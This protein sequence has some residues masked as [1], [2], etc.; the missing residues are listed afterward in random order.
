[1]T[2]RIWAPK[3]CWRLAV[4]LVL[5]LSKPPAALAGTPAQGQRHL[6]IG[7]IA[8][9][10]RTFV[11]RGQPAGS[12]LELWRQLARQLGLSTTFVQHDGLESLFRSL[13]TGQL[14]AAVGSFTVTPDRLRRFPLTLSTSQTTYALYRQSTL[15]Q[16]LALAAQIVTSQD[17]L[18]AYAL[19]AAIV[20]LLALPT[21]FWE[22][23]TG[24][25]LPARG[26]V[27]EWIYFTQQ[28]LL[29]GTG[30]ATRS[31]TRVLS[32]VAKFLTQIFVAAV[33]A[34]FAISK[35]NQML[36]VGAV[37]SLTELRNLKGPVAVLEGSFIAVELENL[38]FQRHTCASVAACLQSVRTG[39]SVAAL[40]STYDADW[41]C[42]R[43]GC[44]DI[45]KQALEMLPQIEAWMLAP[46]SPLVARLPEINA[47]IAMSYQNGSYQKLV[48]RYAALP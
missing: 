11:W 23:Q 32:I 47:F 8:D 31:R 4:V 40:L 48:D 13:S 21:W 2:T 6:R 28:I 12:Q 15:F 7:W 14:D 37:T 36:P 39:Q 1:M 44:Q 33:F 34:S 22:K 30:H 9:P 35:Y 27:H 43:G 26:F 17:A 46:Q 5:V 18:K 38:G 29:S 41:S 20:V 3:G 16:P 19:F 42:R 45:S 10:P 25:P 24:R